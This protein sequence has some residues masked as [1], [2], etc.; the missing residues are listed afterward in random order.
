MRVGNN[1]AYCYATTTTNNNN[2]NNAGPASR[3]TDLLH[4]WHVCIL[5]TPAHW[6]VM[7]GT[8]RP[9]AKRQTHLHR[10]A[11]M[12]NGKVIHSNP[13]SWNAPT[14]TP[15]TLSPAKLV[16]PGRRTARAARGSACHLAVCHP[17]G[18]VTRRA[19]EGS[20]RSST[21]CSTPRPWPASERRQLKTQ[22]KE[23]KE[24]PRS[25]GPGRQHTERG[26]ARGGGDGC[27]AV[28]GMAL[29]QATPQ[30][31]RD[32]PCPAASALPR[33]LGAAVSLPPSLL[34]ALALYRPC[35][36]SVSPPYP[37]CLLPLSVWPSLA[38]AAAR[39]PV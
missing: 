7:S 14:H 26:G 32:L 17:V 19:R 5:H 11:D 12:P 23:R 31:H 28:D 15:L 25:A 1:W 34:P 35:P 6:Q 33:P 38:A 10:C 24:G 21:Q 30:P 20:P 2:N 39:R 18:V 29:R 16:L 3:H 36:S 9:E 37:L 8:S 13:L 4:G 22:V 27:S